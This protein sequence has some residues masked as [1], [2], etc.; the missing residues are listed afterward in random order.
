ML[1]SMDM[2]TAARY[3]VSYAGLRDETECRPT[4]VRLRA[5]QSLC[6]IATPEVVLNTT[7]QTLENIKYVLCNV[8]NKIPYNLK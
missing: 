1:Q 4:S 6:S 8:K 3:L 5:L 7:G 2:E